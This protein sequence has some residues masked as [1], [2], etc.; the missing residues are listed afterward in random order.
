MKQVTVQRPRRLLAGHP[1]V[2]SNELKGSPRGHEPGEIV[3]L[4][5]ARRRPLGTGYINPHSLIAVRVLSRQREVVDADFLRRRLQ[6]AFAYRARFAADTRSG[7]LVF[8]EGDDLP[9]LIVDR[10]ND[11]LAVQ[12]LT[13]GMERLREQVLEVL[14]DLLAPRTIVLRN[15]GR[16]RDLEG[17]PREKSVVKG[18]L[19]PLPVIE[20]VDLRF[21]VDPLN[22]QKTGFFFDQR[23]N[24]ILFAMLASGHRALDLCAYHGAWAMHLAR[25]GLRVTAVDASAPA[26]AQLQRNL[27]RNQLSDRV[28]TVQS[29]VFEMLE[30]DSSAQYDAVVVDPPAFAKSRQ[31]QREALRAYRRLNTLAL[32]RVA[33]GGLVASSSCSYHVGREAFVE[34]L[35]QAARDAGRQVRLLELRGQAADHPVS[36][37][38]AEGAYLK[39]AL[40]EVR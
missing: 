15:D 11:V 31:K 17:L 2:F 16:S 9:G 12:L 10:Y 25:A 14:D 34:M 20:E 13:Q 36:L 40:L 35:G 33:P 18:S 30:A 28:E 22:G 6:A 8:S 5:D 4:L 26:L 1:W 27:K 3:E 32:R 39:C 19:E 38:F 37:N 24:R 23:E 7:R 21:E 29:D